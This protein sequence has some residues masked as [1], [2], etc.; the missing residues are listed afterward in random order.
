MI[1]LQTE[2]V[3]NSDWVAHVLENRAGTYYYPTGSGDMFVFFL[4]R[5]LQN[6]SEVRQHLEPTWMI[7]E[8]KERFGVEADSL[9]L[10]ARI[11]AAT[12]VDMA[13]S[14]DLETLLSLQREDGSWGD[15]WI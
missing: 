6:F 1:L 7:K 2:G 13:D 5:L 12:G 8:I 10:A 15:S 4:S 9:S 11:L 3:M 14:R